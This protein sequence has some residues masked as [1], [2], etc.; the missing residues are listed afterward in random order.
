MENIKSIDECISTEMSSKVAT[1]KKVS[2]GGI[3]ALVCGFA[4]LTLD[5]YYYSSHPFVLSDTAVTLILTVGIVSLC[6]G[7]VF[8]LMSISGAITYNLYIPT[9]SRMKR[10]K[11]Y[12]TADSYHKA[13]EGLRSGDKGALGLLQATVTSNHVLHVLCSKDDAFMMVQLESFDLGHGELETPV[14]CLE[15][16]EAAQLKSALQKRQ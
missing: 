14:I 7:L 13:I 10:Q 16:P 11:C 9:H 2:L 1:R 15:G 4:L 5:H 6:T 3:L 12:I 8:T